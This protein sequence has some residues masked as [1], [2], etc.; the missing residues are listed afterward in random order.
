[1]GLFKNIKFATDLKIA[2]ASVVS[3]QTDSQ[4]ETALASAAHLA[5][6]ISSQWNRTRGMSGSAKDQLFHIAV[7]IEVGKTLLDQN[8]GSVATIREPMNEA[9]LRLDSIYA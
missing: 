5:G 9:Y 1:M 2:L 7:T 8:P 6:S 4:F 3:A